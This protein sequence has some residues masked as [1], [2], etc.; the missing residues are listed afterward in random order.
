MNQPIISGAMQYFRIHPDLWRDRLQGLQAMGC[1]TVETYVAWNWHEARRGEPDFTGGRDVEAFL[2]TAHSLGLQAI[3]RPGPYICAEWDAGGLPGWLLADPT[4]Q[5]RTSDPRYLDLV[6]TWFDALIP[7]IAALQHSRGGPVIAV[8][9]ENEYGSY[10]SDRAYLEHLRDGLVRR[11]ID[12]P[13]FTADGPTDRMLTGGTLP[14]VWK[15]V[16][17]GSRADQAFSIFADHDPAGPLMCME[18]W[19]GWFDHWGEPHHVR[20]AE[21]A[22][23]ALEEILD[24]GGAV[25]FYM[26]HGGT[27]FGF[28]AG[29]NAH[30]GGYQ[31]TVT[32]YDYDAPIGEAGELTEKFHAFRSVL[33]RRLHLELP[34]PPATP[35]RLAPQSTRVDGSV[36]LLA[37]LGRLSTVRR[38][39]SPESME[40]YGQQSGLILY[41]TVLPGPFPAT[42]LRISGVRD[43]AQVFLDGHLIGTLDRLRPEDELTVTVDGPSA[44]L[45]ILV[46]GL[47]RINYGPVVADRKGLLQPVRLDYQ[48]VNGWDV[49]PLPLDDLSGVLFGDLS[50]EPGFHRAHLVIDQPADGFL[51]LPGWQRGVLWLN[52][53]NLGRYRAAGPQRTL[54]A[55]GPLWRAGV[56]ELVILELDG[57]GSDVELRSEPDLGP[58]APA[59]DVS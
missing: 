29:A 40:R 34:D 19:N 12:V 17:F 9:V 11:G 4:L 47:G 7:R 23:A 50:V 18:F 22:A 43:R 1:N 10:G 58:T 46:E 51:A 8:Q 2:R 5:L 30:E 25:N 39:A 21:Q 38:A 15:T 24:A 44:V 27:N 49:F 54:F 45:E 36:G 55:P 37:Q 42:P 16:N 35:P 6:D 33:A 41:R 14:G 48:Q 20:P 13:L 31:P 56:N 3:V 52:G 59:P 26:A 32:S 28:W 57:V 53:F